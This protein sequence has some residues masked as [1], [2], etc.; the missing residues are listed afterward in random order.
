MGFEYLIHSGQLLFKFSHCSMKSRGHVV[1]MS[2][3][4]GFRIRWNS[5]SHRRWAASERCENYRIAKD[6]VEHVGRK[7]DWRHRVNERE[8]APLVGET[9][10]LDRFWLAI[11]SVEPFWVD[12]PEEKPQDA[13]SAAAEIQN[14]SRHREAAAMVLEKVSE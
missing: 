12:I 4:P 11:E 14:R 10:H 2:R 8:P 13:A 3:P 1:A 9:A 5:V 6:H 7:G